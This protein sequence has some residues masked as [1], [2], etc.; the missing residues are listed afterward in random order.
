MRPKAT[1]LK[2]KKELPKQ[3][4]EISRIL[5]R[6]GYFKINYP[7]LGGGRLREEGQGEK[8]P[9]H[10]R[11]EFLMGIVLVDTRDCHLSIG[12]SFFRKRMLL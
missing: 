12:N 4:K 8:T 7:V 11:R 3:V 1:E 6:K 2:K 5:F 10:G 9:S